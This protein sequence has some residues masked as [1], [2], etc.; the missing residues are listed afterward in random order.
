MSNVEELEDYLKK[1]GVQKFE[2]RPEYDSTRCHVLIDK[3]HYT[4]Y[5]E[6]IQAWQKVGVEEF[7]KARFSK[8]LKRKCLTCD[9]EAAT[10]VH[11]DNVLCQSCREYIEQ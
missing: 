9:E 4:L 6:D 11:P 7:A 5:K 10:Y 2:F 3:S 1:N 8:H